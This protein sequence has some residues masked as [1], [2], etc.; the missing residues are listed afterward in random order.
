[1]ASRA[2]APSSTPWVSVPI[3]CS[4]VPIAF[5]TVA[6]TS[7]ATARESSTLRSVLSTSCKMVAERSFKS[8]ISCHATMAPTK[9]RDRGDDRGDHHRLAD[10]VAVEESLSSS[11]ALLAG[12]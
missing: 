10:A 3:D 8:P 2:V 12:R 5:P 9:K 1:M 7:W 6:V 11:R 4:I